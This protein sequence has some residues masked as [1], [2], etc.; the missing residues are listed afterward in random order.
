MKKSFFIIALLS[1]TFT[2]YSQSKKII[3]SWILRDSIVAMQ[4]FT[5]EDG[6]IKERSGLANENIW[7]KAQRTGTY[8]F[9]NKGKLVITWSDKSIENREVKFENNFKAAKI[10][11][12]DKKDTPKK[13]YLFLR[14][15]DE[16]VVPDK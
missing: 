11:F 6:T 1:L 16:E 5:N 7:D 12:T 4:F 13:A 8:T 15:M 10:K 3:G 9:N 2:C 14:V